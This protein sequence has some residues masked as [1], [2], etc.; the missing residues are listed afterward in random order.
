GLSGLP[1]YWWWAV[2]PG[3]AILIIVVGFVLLG[4]RLQDVIAGR[5]VY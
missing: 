5:I 2:F 1:Q 4:D 3:L